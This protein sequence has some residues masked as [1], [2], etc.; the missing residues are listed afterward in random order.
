MKT[1]T[2]DNFGDLTSDGLT[3][4]MFSAPWAGPCNL[5]R[6][7]FRSVAARFGNQITFAEFDLDDNPDTPA[8]FGVRSVPWFLLMENGVPVSVKAGDIPEEVLVDVCN[9]VLGGT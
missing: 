4:V 8:R 9:E 1:A 7:K 6:P 2:D 3:Y 5:A